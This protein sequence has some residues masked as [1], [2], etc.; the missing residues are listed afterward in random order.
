MSQNHVELVRALVELWNSGERDFAD[1]PS[2]LDSAIELE[3]PFSSVV[4]E[5]YRGY[6]GIEQWVRDIDEQFAEWSIVVDELRTAGVRVLA[7][8]TVHARGRASDVS[9]QFAAATVYDFG[10]DDRITRIRIYL[11]VAEALALVG[12]DG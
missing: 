11:D 12:L 7:L 9:L 6:A 2:Y 3:S 10:S 1:L 4:G 8:A 5:P